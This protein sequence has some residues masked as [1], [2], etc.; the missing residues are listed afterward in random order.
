MRPA[1]AIFLLASAL[2][3]VDSQVVVHTGTL[4]NFVPGLGACGFTNTSSQ[5]VASVSNHTF[6]TFAGATANPNNNPICKHSL[7]ITHGGTHLAVPI[8]DFCASCP[9]ENIG[10][11]TP[12]FVHFAPTSAGIV[13][14]VSWSIV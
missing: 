13:T 12:G 11:S 5:T 4:F 7:N 3:A 9:D 2:V 10:L 14:G 6:N 8:V 1:F